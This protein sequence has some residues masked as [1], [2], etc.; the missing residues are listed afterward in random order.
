MTNAIQLTNEVEVRKS[1]GVSKSNSIKQFTFETIL[2]TSFSLLLALIFV[3][4]S[5][6][7]YN[8][9]FGKELIIY[10]KQFYTQSLLFF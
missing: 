7:H 5:L 3:E 2:F 6:S 1:N 9:F 4:L 8:K 10:S